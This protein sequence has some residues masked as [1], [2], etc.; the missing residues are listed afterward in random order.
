MQGAPHTA[1]LCEV[2]SL[3]DSTD[4]FAMSKISCEM[5]G[6]GIGFFFIIAF[7][8]EQIDRALGGH[9]RIHRNLTIQQLNMDE[10]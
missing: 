10:S 3:S 1:H 4:F 2:D 9:A 6:S 5:I 7:T 8:I